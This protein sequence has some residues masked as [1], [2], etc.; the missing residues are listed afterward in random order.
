MHR[1]EVAEACVNAMKSYLSPPLYDEVG[2]IIV[3][4]MLYAAEFSQSEYSLVVVVKYEPTRRS[5]PGRRFSLS[6]TRI[7]RTA[8]VSPPATIIAMRH[9]MM[10]LQN[11]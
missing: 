3:L 4:S 10:R 8:E 7:V 2:L 1:L 11:S 6:H 5:S 9:L